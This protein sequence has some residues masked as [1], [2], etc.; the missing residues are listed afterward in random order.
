MMGMPVICDIGNEVWR[1]KEAKTADAP[2]WGDAGKRGPMW[3]AATA[4]C[5]LQ[6]GADILRMR[7]P[8]AIATV[9]NF[10]NE[11]W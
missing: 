6:A 3:E 10:I 9:K 5:L 1:T 4:V 7:H 11:L 2:D 8:K